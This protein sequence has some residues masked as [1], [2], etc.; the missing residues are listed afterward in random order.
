M[1]KCFEQFLLSDKKIRADE[2]STN[3]RKLDSD[4][5]SHHN[6]QKK[7]SLYKKRHTRFSGNLEIIMQIP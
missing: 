1:S 5:D 7:R 3:E 4:L 6:Y 2:G